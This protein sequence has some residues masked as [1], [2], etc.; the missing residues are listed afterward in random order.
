[1]CKSIPLPLV[2]L[3]LLL[4]PARAAFAQEPDEAVVRKAI[5]TL[6]GDDRKEC[7]KALAVLANSTN[8][9]VRKRV[10]DFG[11]TT[12]HR[13]LTIKV[14]DILAAHDPEVAKDEFT[15]R[16]PIRGSKEPEK[17]PDDQPDD[18]KEP[19]EPGGENQPPGGKGGGGGGDK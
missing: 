6:E 19:Q 4:V 10:A 12:D 9:K 7:A 5:K 11:A 18:P 16:A 2:L 14:G 1:M 8:E 15:A 17:P 3:V 13:Q